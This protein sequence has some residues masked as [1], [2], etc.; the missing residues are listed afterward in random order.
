VEYS[1]NVPNRVRLFNTPV[2]PKNLAK[3]LGFF[4]QDS[5]S[6]GNRL[7]LNLGMRFDKYNGILPEQSNP[8]GPFIEARSIPEQEVI[9]Q[10]VAVW[11]SGIVFDPTGSGRTALKASYSRYGLQVGI[12][13]VT[14]VN[15]LGSG[16]RTCP[17]SDPNNDGKFQLSEITLSQCGGFSGGINTFYPAGR[18]PDWPYSDEVTAGVERQV[19]RDMRVGLMF[20]YRTNRDQTGTRNLAVPPTAYTAYTVTIPN[21]PGGTVANPKPM[22]ATVYNLA[23]SLA[24]AENNIR[25]NDPYFDTEYKGVELTASKRFSSKWQMVGGLTI[26][27]NEGGLGGGDLNDPNTLTYPRGIIGNDS[28]VAFRLSGS[29]QLPY[30]L[31]LAGSVVANSGYPFASPYSLTRANAALQGITL[32]RSTQTITLSQRGDERYPSVKMADVRI[33]RSFR[34]GDRRFQP[35]LDIFNIG[36]ASSVV[37]Y[38]TAV[39]STYMEPREILSPR[40]IR[41]GFSLNF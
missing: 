38:N 4:V 39:G 16:S 10:N 7:T 20:Y 6:I 34:F 40:I 13:R 32:T 9:D 26:G 17:W 29:Y 5:W 25:D 18:S 1:N 2:D 23:S 22:T 28:K 35:Q 24:S 12:D 19:M 37:S 30:G 15:P 8:G 3:V 31:A 36:N 14:A 33:S 27:K 41:V 11:R 21:G